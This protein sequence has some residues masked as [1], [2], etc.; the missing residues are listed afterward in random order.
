MK[1]A[2]DATPLTYSFGA[3]GVCPSRGMV[4]NRL[5]GHGESPFASLNISLSVGDRLETVMANRRLVKERT[6]VARLLS[7]RQV[8]GDRVYVL[9]K[10]LESDLEVDGFDSLIT[11]RVGVGLVIQHADCQAVLLHDAGGGAIGAVHCGWRGS[12]ANLLAKSVDAMGREFGT[13]PERLQAVISPS[14]GPCCAEFVNHEREL[15]PEFR[16][17]MVGESHF[18]F[19]R[20]SRRQL[21]EA[22]VRPENIRLPTICTSCS[23]D[24]FSYRRACRDGDGTTGRNCSLIALIED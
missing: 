19:W 5:H 18:D 1:R 21:T 23:P 12:V 17:F 8:H 15:P 20:I 3:E 14:L 22:G 10:E 13:R 16:E 24:Y 6:G 4:F 7:A 11:D 2:I 9:R